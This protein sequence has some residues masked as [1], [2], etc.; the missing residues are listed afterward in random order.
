[1]IVNT[2]DVYIGYSLFIVIR[3]STLLFIVQ[4]DFV[5]AI[6]A[7]VIVDDNLNY[8]GQTNNSF[9][10]CKSYQDMIIKKKIPKF[11]FV[12]SINV[13]LCQKYFN[14]FSNLTLINI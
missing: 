4:L 11:R 3:A 1:M 8:Y 5:L 7:A 12:N 2:N 10:F 9:K 6:K 13:L 14:I